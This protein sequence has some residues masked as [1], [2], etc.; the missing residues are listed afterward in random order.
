[1]IALNI[2]PHRRDPIYRQIKDQISEAVA[3]GHLSP[4]DALWSARRIAA[5][6]RISYQTAERALAQLAKAGI[7]TRSVGGGTIVASQ[8][9]VHDGSVRRSKS[10]LIA[11]LNCWQVFDGDHPLYTLSELREIQAAAQELTLRMWGMLFA[12]F[13]TEQFT[14]A[15]L[16]DWARQHRFDGVLVF[17]ELPL[18]ALRWLDRQGYGVV[19]VDADP[20]NVPCPRVVQDNS[21]GIQQ[22][23]QHLAERGHRRIAYL[24]GVA[25]Y[26]YAVRQT[27]YET[28]CQALGLDYDPALI[29]TVRRPHPTVEEAVR[30]ALKAEPTALVV[31]S[32][33]LA[34]FVVR[35]LQEMGK[36]I[37]DDISVVGFD[38]EPF[39]QTL[40]PP[41]T[42][43]RIPFEELGRQGAR[44]LLGQLEGG[45][46]LPTRVVVPAQ[47][48]V[49]ESVATLSRSQP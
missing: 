12:S 8:P 30:R 39:C 23:I 27:A 34:A 44:L 24:R 11:M 26:H 31:G 47:L 13:P 21:G 33:I 49:R 17:G 42:T 10:R 15:H 19:V 36:T 35:V 5:H 18:S 38:D 46:D 25:P 40:V 28:A 45:T 41:L 20:D 48:V 2:D 32:D 9:S 7:V 14:V 37:P 6:Y 43:V 16:A 29:V 4:G 3:E 22:V 1:M